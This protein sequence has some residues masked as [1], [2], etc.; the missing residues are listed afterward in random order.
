MKKLLLILLCLPMIGF[1]QNIP[2]TKIGNQFWSSENLDIDIF[3][4]GDIIPQA[5]NKSEWLKAG[6]REEPV[7]CYY[8]FD[9]KNSVFGKL[10]NY[11]AVSD[12]RGLAP[13]GWHVPSLYEYFILIN[14]IEP[15]F[16]LEML[17]DRESLAGGS[18]KIKN[19]KYWSGKVCPQIDCGFNAIAA[20]GYSPSVDYPE[21]DWDPIKEH[22]RFWLLTNWQEIVNL[23]GLFNDED[24]LDFLQRESAGKFEDKAIVM[25]LKNSS[26]EVSIDDDPKIYGYS[27]RLIK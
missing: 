21:Y 17:E 1:G 18:L 14:S 23:P 3:R 9:E 22:A 12:E 19:D 5:T 27:I 7:W 4:N 11:Y 6:Y 2:F 16:T 20:G 24:K 13:V 15:L 26:C 10:Y 25:R 8:K